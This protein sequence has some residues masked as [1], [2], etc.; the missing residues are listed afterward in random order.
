MVSGPGP[1]EVDRGQGA[2]GAVGPNGV[3]LD[4][5]DHP[6]IRQEE[7]RARTLRPQRPAHR[8]AGPP[9]L[10]RDDR[11]TGSCRQGPQPLHR[12]GRDPPCALATAAWLGRDRLVA[13][14]RRWPARSSTAT[15]AAT[16]AGG[17]PGRGSGASR[18]GGPVPDSSLLPDLASLCA[19]PAAPRSAITRTDLTDLTRAVPPIVDVAGPGGGGCRLGWAGQAARAGVGSGWGSGSMIGGAGIG[20][21]GRLAGV[22]S[23]WLGWLVWPLSQ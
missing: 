2:Q 18:G 16:A 7:A 12:H 1:G 21:P 4:P 6:P 15:A 10:R 5:P 3:V 23:P 20:A 22:W 8:R 13:G 11:L 14:R 19:W 9:G 17:R